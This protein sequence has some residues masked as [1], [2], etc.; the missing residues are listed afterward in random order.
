MYM[1]ESLDADF[2]I[3]FLEKLSHQTP[4]FIFSKKTISAKLKEF[5]KNFPGAD[6][7]YAMKANAEEELLK[8]I[9]KAGV[10]F[11]AASKYELDMLKEI[12]VPAEKIIYGTSVKPASHIKDFFDYGVD[13]FAFDSM[14]ELQKIASVAPGSKVYVRVI[15]NE[16]GSVFQFSHKF[17]TDKENIVPF[18]QK[19]KE[20]GLIPYGISFHVGS[21][22]SNP[23]AWVNALKEIKEPIEELEKIGIKIEVINLGGGFPCKYLSSENAPTIEEI[24]KHTLDAYRKLSLKP[25][26]AIEP[27]RAVVAESGIL[28]TSVI[29]RVEREENTWLFLDA[30]VYS[31]LFEAMAYQGSTRYQITSLRPSYDSGEMMFALAGPT[32]D[33]PDIITKEAMLPKDIDVGDKL[34]IHNVGAYSLPAASKFNGFPK[35]DV[36]FI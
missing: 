15:V 33:S 7:Y 20:L 5:E 9:S 25:K 29:A 10:G 13:T 12:N 21:Q 2:N 6:I 28:I 24:A 14:Q 23:M 19:T 27:G 36:Y 35:P 34:I 26:L 1:Q 32:G 3:E 17:G 22:A 16:T 18:L 8:T 11:E 4:F 31:G 30:G